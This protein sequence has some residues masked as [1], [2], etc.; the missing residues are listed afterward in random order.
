MTAAPA[1]LTPARAGNFD[2]LLAVVGQLA[3]RVEQLERLVGAGVVAERRRV[4]LPDGVGID[5]GGKLYS[6]PS[7]PAQIVAAELFQLWES[8]PGAGMLDAT[9]VGRIVHAGASDAKTIRI[10]LMLS[11]RA[12]GIWQPLPA[13]AEG[14]IERLDGG[15]WRLRP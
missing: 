1:N 9:L 14:L 13:L 2:D 15:A 4:L 3:A 11:S 10:P 6:F 8:Q 5:D 12:G 7:R